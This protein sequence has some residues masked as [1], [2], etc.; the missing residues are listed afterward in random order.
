MEK[1]AG[2][3]L[4]HLR[5]RAHEYTHAQDYSHHLKIKTGKQCQGLS[6]FFYNMFT[7][8]ALWVLSGLKGII[9]CE[10]TGFKKRMKKCK[11]NGV[12]GCRATP[13]P[14][15]WPIPSSFAFSEQG[16]CLFLLITNHQ[17]IGSIMSLS[18]VTKGQPRLTGACPVF[19]PGWVIGDG[20]KRR[21]QKWKDTRKSFKFKPNC[22]QPPLPSTGHLFPH[23]LSLSLHL[24]GKPIQSYLLERLHYQA[25]LLSL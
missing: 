23:L 9:N 13:P 16:P 21:N 12:G 19:C 22:C 14:P 5:N 8:P 18:A 6:R 3:L 2:P 11:E 7:F 25:P 4:P 24:L 17:W 1:N 10:E 15:C 20:K